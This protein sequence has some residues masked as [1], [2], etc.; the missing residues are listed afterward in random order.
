MNIGQKIKEI[1]KRLG[2]TQTDLSKLISVSL[3]TVSRWER[4]TRKPRVDDFQKIASALGTT[5]AYL[6][7]EADGSSCAPVPAAAGAP[8]SG[9]MIDLR[10]IPLLSIAA[11]VSCGAGNGLYGVDPET[12]EHIYVPGS[13]FTRLDDTRLPFAIHTEGDSM[14]GAGIEEGSVAVINPAEDTLDGD[15]ALVCYNDNW[16]IKWVMFV[17]DGSVELRSANPNYAPIRID[18]EYAQDPSWF[19]IIGKVVSIVRQSRPRRAF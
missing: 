9:Q 15:A 19:R 1:R 2:Y 10:S 18:K 3:D 5:V 4:G 14:E 6:I 16:Y 7:G 12:T 11:A 17:P 13:L 8:Q